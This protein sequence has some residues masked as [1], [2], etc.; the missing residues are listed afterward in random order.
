MDYWNGPLSFRPLFCCCARFLRQADQTIPVFRIIHYLHFTHRVWSGPLACL[1]GPSPS[2]RVPPPLALLQQLQPESWLKLCL[3]PSPSTG[4]LLCF[5]AC[6]CLVIYFLAWL[7]SF[8]FDKA[9]VTQVFRQNTFPSLIGFCSQP[10]IQPLP[11][12]CRENQLYMILSLFCW[13]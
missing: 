13:L 1:R 4:G 9:F 5:S 8:L 10:P 6:L 3:L 11:R 12:V 7:T 2:V